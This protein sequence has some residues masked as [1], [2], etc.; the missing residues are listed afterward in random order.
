MRKHT[1]FRVGRTTRCLDFHGALSAI[2][3]ITDLIPVQ[4]LFVFNGTS[5]RRAL[6]AVSGS[7]PSKGARALMCPSSDLPQA[8]DPGPLRAPV[9]AAQSLL[10]AMLAGR[11]A[12]VPGRAV[13][14]GTG[15]RPA[16][17]L[18]AISGSAGDATSAQ[19]R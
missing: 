13:T 17:G 18:A 9:L 3:T 7:V 4:W 2:T 15:P 10:C 14:I 1:A 8:G 12:A 5:S 19:I 6:P 11:R 16:P